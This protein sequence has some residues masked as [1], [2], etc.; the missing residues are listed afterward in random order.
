MPWLVEWDKLDCY[1][2]EGPDG[3]DKTRVVWRD[4]IYR[5]PD[6]EIRHWILRCGKWCLPLLSLAL[7]GAQIICVSAEN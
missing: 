3:P 5:V 1:G 7:W 6:C 2:M 4:E